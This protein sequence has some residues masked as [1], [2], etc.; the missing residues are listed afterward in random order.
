MLEMFHEDAVVL[1]KC[2]RDVPDLEQAGVIYEQLR[3]ER[4]V[5]MYEV[6]ERGDAG[7]YVVEPLKQ[8]FRDLT[9]PIFLK[10]FANPKASNW[11]YSYRI[12]WDEPIRADPSA[13]RRVK[14]R[15]A[16]LIRRSRAVMVR[17]RIAAAVAAAARS[18][19]E[20]SARVML[21]H[22]LACYTSHRD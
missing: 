20:S 7:K 15:S 5:K 9:T 3:R 17:R 14:K 2:L 18:P 10:L 6:G 19:L 13:L 8:W 12:D 16:L 11:M 22:P 1:A 4:T 21:R